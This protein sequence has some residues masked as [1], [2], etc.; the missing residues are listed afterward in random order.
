MRKSDY[1]FNCILGLYVVYTYIRLFEKN[2]T[3]MIIV[4][5]ILCVTSVISFVYKIRGRNKKR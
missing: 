4:L 5:T 3:S 1:I 2:D